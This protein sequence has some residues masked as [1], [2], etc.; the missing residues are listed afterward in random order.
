[1]KLSTELTL[2]INEMKSALAILEDS[3]VRVAL[4][5][6]DW[7]RIEDEFA[8]VTEEMNKMMDKN[9]LLYNERHHFC[10]DILP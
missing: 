4:S 2:I 8:K 6:K 5:K 1:M 3:S 7:R 9:A 10:K